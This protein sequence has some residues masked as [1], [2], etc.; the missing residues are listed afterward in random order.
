MSRKMRVAITR[1]R[2]L[3]TELE[4]A[5]LIQ[6]VTLTQQVKLATRRVNTSKSFVNVSIPTHI[7]KYAIDLFVDELMDDIDELRV[8]IIEE[9][10]KT[11]DR[12]HP[13]IKA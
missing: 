4:N 13:N 11:L 3:E 10:Q 5:K 1:L 8:I 7:A 9:T 12:L 6:S 2:A